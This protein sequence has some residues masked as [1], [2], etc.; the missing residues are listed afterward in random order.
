ASQRRDYL[1]AS[2]GWFRDLLMLGFALLLLVVTGL[3]LSGSDFALIPLQGNMSLLPMLLI[4]VA[5]ICMSW[6]LHHWTTISWRRAGKALLIS[7]SAA[8]VTALACVQGLTH[9]EG[10]FLR[11]SKTDGERHEL[12]TAVRI[13]RAETALALALYASAGLLIVSADPPVPL[14]VIIGLQATVYLCA[15][16]A[17]VWN[18]RTQ[19]RPAHEYRQRFELQR[20][21]QERR[22]P[23][24]FVTVGFVSAVVL[25][26]VTGVGIGVFAAPTKLIPAR[27][28]TRAPT[29][30][31]AP[32]AF[33]S[34][35]H[36][37]R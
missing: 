21:R 20:L 19:R 18:V 33:T 31:V 29:R 12:R 11:T 15:P 34:V 4:I 23:R 27:A 22:P 10:V 14:I 2:L 26:V 3:L 1:M 36:L 32:V 8:W 24:V 28:A 6:T 7:L 30:V 5:T 9:R 13:T 35:T 25:A 17:A 16:I 37:L